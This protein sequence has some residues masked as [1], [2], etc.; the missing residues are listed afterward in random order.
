MPSR[1]RRCTTT[2]RAS[3]CARR[4]EGNGSASDDRD[5][6][7]PAALDQLRGDLGERLEALDGRL[8][9]VRA[10][11]M[12]RIDRLQDALTAQ[13]YD[14]VVNFGAEPSAR[15]RPWRARMRPA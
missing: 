6:H 3:A 15:R 9:Q 13:R 12:G 7:I 2:Q 5:A 11:V 8:V 14:D 4:E 10:D 1:R